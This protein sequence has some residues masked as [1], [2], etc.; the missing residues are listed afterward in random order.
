MRMFFGRAT[1]IV[2]ASSLWPLI[3]RIAVFE[4]GDRRDVGEPSAWLVAPPVFAALAAIVL[5]LNPD[6]GARFWSLAESAAQ[7]VAAHAPE[8]LTGGLP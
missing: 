3:H 2:Y 8:F 5:G 7:S 1:Q 4:P 6:A